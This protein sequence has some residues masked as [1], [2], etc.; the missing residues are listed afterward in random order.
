MA[1]LLEALAKSSRSRILL[2]GDVRSQRPKPSEPS[3]VHP[4]RV[5]PYLSFV[6]NL[7]TEDLGL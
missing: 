2:D 7:V 3:F 4:L 6:R 1:L 5:K